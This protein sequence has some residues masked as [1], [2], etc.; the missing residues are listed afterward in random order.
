MVQPQHPARDVTLTGDLFYFE[1]RP[2]VKDFFYQRYSYCVVQGCAVDMILYN[3]CTVNKWH[4][5]S[6]LKSTISKTKSSQVGGNGKPIGRSPG[7]Q[8]MFFPGRPIFFKPVYTFCLFCL[9]YRLPCPGEQVI[10]F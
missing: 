2:S 9:K 4:E 5:K 10:Y 1:S 7:C 8:K 6:H 3:V